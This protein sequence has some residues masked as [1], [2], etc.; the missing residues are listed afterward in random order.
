M[1]SLDALIQ[2][3]QDFSYFPNNWDGEGGCAAN[4]ESLDNAIRF[5]LAMP[6]TLPEPMLMANGNIGLL[7][8]FEGFYLDIEFIAGYR[9]AYFSEIEGCKT[10]G[11]AKLDPSIP[12]EIK[13]LLDQLKA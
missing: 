9:V 11:V 6:D 12:T 1:S 2:E 13:S 3:I 5:A 10:K 8:D 7:W 4:P